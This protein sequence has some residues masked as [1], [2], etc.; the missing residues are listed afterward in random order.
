MTDGGNCCNTRP[1]L[2]RAAKIVA[3]PSTLTGS[4]GV[5]SGMLDWSGFLKQQKVKMAVLSKG[6]APLSPNAAPS[7]YATSRP[8][9]WLWYR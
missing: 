9:S 8:C 1:A 5:L 4:I 2:A 6:G 7:P 3:M